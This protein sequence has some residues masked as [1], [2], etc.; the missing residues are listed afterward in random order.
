MDFF[1]S[2]CIKKLKSIMILNF[3]IYK[4][5]QKKTKKIYI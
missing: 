5:K 3:E 1:S 2:S 4:E